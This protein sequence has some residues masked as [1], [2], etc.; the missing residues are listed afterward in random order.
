MEGGEMGEVYLFTNLAL[1]YSY[2]ASTEPGKKTQSTLSKLAISFV[3]VRD[4]GDMGGS[5]EKP[6]CISRLW[7]TDA[8]AIAVGMVVNYSQDFSACWRACL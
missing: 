2:V 8:V 3:K 7:A 4:H 1:Y 5:I 6:G